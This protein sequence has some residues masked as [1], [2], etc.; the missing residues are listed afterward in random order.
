MLCLR[1]I[2][3]L[4]NPGHCPAA[5]G[6]GADEQRSGKRHIAD[7]GEERPRFDDRLDLTGDTHTLQEL[8]MVL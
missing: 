3:Y 5:T 4:S 7:C 6:V 8:L 2:E 1:W